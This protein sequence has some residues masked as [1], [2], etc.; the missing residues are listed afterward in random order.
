MAGHSHWA[1]IKHKKAL[2]D[3]KRGQ[4]WSKMSKA[5]IMAAKLG[6]GDPDVNFRLRAAIDDA[7]AGG[8]PKDNITRAIKKGPGEIAGGTIEE[9]VYEGYGPNG[10]AMVQLA[11]DG[12]QVVVTV[13][14][15]VSAFEALDAAADAGLDVIVVDHHAAEAKLPRAL[16]VINPNRLD[17][18]GEFGALAAVGVA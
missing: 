3:A 7:K 5:I 6:G 10:P 15:G 13:D 18:T 11:K 2:V 14:C 4:L 1:G 12:A 9:V 16:G 8:V 17:E